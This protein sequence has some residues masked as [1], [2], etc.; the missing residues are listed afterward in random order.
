MLI[1]TLSFPVRHPDEASVPIVSIELPNA[2]GRRRYDAVLRG[3]RRLIDRSAW[4]G[5]SANFA[6]IGFSE[7]RQ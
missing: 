4:K 7:V 2:K 3:L 6:C 5:R 1:A